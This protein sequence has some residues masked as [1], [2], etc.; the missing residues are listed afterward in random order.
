MDSPKFTPSFL[1]HTAFVLAIRSFRLTA[2]PLPAWTWTP[3]TR[4]SAK[5]QRMTFPSLFVIARSSAL[6]QCTRIRTVILAFNSTTAKSTQLSK[7]HRLP[8]MASWSII[9]YWRWTDKMWS[10][11]KT[12]S[13]RPSSIRRNKLSQ[14]PL[15]H[16]SS[17]ITWWRSECFRFAFRCICY[18][19]AE[20][21]NNFILFGFQLQTVDII[22]S[23]HHGSFTSRPISSIR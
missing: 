20:K 7:T 18:P 19:P 2:S 9:N 14:S 3:F 15:F 16:H 1:L 5:A 23:R 22:H 6:L 11:W 10:A 13:S 8:A 21:N 4:S 12:K 17:T